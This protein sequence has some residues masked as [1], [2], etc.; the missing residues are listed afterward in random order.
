M[1]GQW[2]HILQKMFQ[3]NQTW[4]KTWKINKKLYSQFLDI[5]KDYNPMHTDPDFAK[6]FGF[7]DKIIHGNIL[8]LFISYFVGEMLPTKNVIIISQKIRYLKPI[9]LNQNIVLKSKLKSFNETMG[10]LEFEIAFKAS[11]TKIAEG[12]VDVKIL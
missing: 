3:I 7:K 4:E 11:R 8:Q 1:Q 2:P 6:S 5:S 10:L 12:K 9:Y